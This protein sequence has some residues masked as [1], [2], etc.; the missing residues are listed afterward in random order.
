[1]IGFLFTTNAWH[2]RHHSAN[3]AESNANYGCAAIVWDRVFGTFGDSGIRE[4]GIGAREPSTMEKLL[5]PVREPYG[6][7]IAPMRETT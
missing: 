3:R 6:S 1:L 4:A 5:M 2:I 7:A